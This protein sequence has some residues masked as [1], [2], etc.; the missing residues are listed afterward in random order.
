[1]VDKM[2]M[3]EVLEDVGAIYIIDKVTGKKK[4]KHKKTSVRKNIRQ[5]IQKKKSKKKDNLFP[6]WS[7]IKA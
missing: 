2:V 7:D 6:K 4:R 5:R 1:V 3:G